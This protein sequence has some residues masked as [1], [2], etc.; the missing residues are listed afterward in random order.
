MPPS[1]REVQLMVVA[2]F[3]L[4]AGIDRGTRQSPGASTLSLLQVIASRDQ[5]RP[6]EIAELQHV[7]PSLVSRQV[8]DLE[9]LGYVSVSAD[10]AD[11]RACLVTL[12][13]TGA[14]ELARLGQI[15]LDRFAM[16]VAD[17][18]PAEVQMFTAL[19][20][21]LEASKAA[22]AAQEHR[23]PGS[24]WHQQSA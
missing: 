3:T 10:P 9:D 7:H 16:F 20:E 21:K 24:R 12:T 5:I 19:L 14:D 13:T 11:R 2:L 17:W 22:V 18:E 8:R 6:S 1:K 15:G 4:I 23:P